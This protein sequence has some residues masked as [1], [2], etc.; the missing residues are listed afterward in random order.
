MVGVLVETPS[1]VYRTALPVLMRQG[2]GA[3]DM[4]KMIGITDETNVCECCGKSNLKRVVVLEDIDTGSIVRYG[5]DCAARAMS[6]KG[7]TVKTDNLDWRYKTISYVRKWIATRDSKLVAQ[8]ANTKF[9][10]LIE[11][12]GDDLHIYFGTKDSLIIVK[13]NGGFE[14]AS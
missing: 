1:G 8:V 13:K 6:V 2:I 7:A 3:N 4:F 11:V 10:A 14:K 9:G 12:H 5:C